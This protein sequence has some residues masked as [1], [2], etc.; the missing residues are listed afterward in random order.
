MLKGLMPVV[1]SFICA[2]ALSTTSTAGSRVNKT[3]RKF[4]SHGFRTW[5]Q[6][7]SFQET[8]QVPQPVFSSQVCEVCVG[9][10]IAQAQAPANGNTGHSVSHCTPALESGRFASS[11]HP[12]SPPT[13]CYFLHLMGMRGEAFVD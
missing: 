5:V 4:A 6:G 12:T 7:P 13:Q 9:V 2:N 11:P 3:G 10:H 1:G 8:H